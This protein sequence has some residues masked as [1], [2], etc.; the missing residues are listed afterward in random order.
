MTLHYS[1]PGKRMW[2][3]DHVFFDEATVLLENKALSKH[4]QI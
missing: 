1:M 4:K 3:S 2:L